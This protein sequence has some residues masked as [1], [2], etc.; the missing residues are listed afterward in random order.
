MYE[1]LVRAVN[2][3]AKHTGPHGLPLMGF[4]DWNDC[5]NLGT[6]KNRAESVMVAQMLVATA[7]E[8]ANLADLLGKKQDANKFRKL[9]ADF[10]GRTNKYAWDGEWYRRGY[11]DDGDPVGSQKNKEGKIY[12][13]T[14][15]WAVLS[16]VAS[17]E[18]A[19]TCMNSVRKHLSTQYGIMILAPAYQD[20][21]HELGSISVYPPGL[22]ENGAI[23]CHPNPWAMVAECILGRGDLAF[24]YYQ[25]ILPA[26]KNEI[27]EIH[28]TEPYVYAQMIAGKEHKNHGEAKNSWLTG[29]AA[30]NFV[31]ATQWIL[32][33]RPDYKGLMV[34]PCIPKSW[35]RFSVKRIFRGN[36]YFI[37]FSN[38][39]GVNKGIANI[40]FDKKEIKGNI[41]PVGRTG[42]T[43]FVEV[44]MG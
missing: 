26:A 35:N 42:S 18:R 12:L 38:P 10:T 23:F 19:L 6:R 2:Y 1:H 39:K 20:F 3:S 7:K 17:P 31:A 13:E 40:I 44:T 22:K 37:K 25:A 16:G 27:A 30:W 33:I 29:T 14:Q 43:H 8:L 41:L 21:H 34:D 24:Q 28:K 9:A 36:T 32:G 4:A 15:P 5:L 11:T